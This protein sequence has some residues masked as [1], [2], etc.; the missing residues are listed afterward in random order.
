[1]LRVMTFNLRNSNAADGA[2]A[3]DERRDFLVDVIRAARVDVLGTQECLAEQGDFLSGRLK[4]Y[5]YLGVCRDDGCR[6]GEAAAILYRRERF[7]EPVDSG[8]FWL[9]E[10][11]QKIGSKGWDAALPRICTWA[12][13]RERDSGQEL[14]FVNTHFDH[15]GERARMESARQ[16]RR[17]I[18]DAGAGMPVVLTGD[19][20]APGD[21][22]VHAALLEGDRLRDAWRVAHPKPLEEE[23]TFHGF[24]GVRNRERIDWIVCSKEF[25]VVSCTTDHTCRDGRYPSDHFPVIAELRLAR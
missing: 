14:L 8:T 1:M 6:E 23:G 5:A 4:E 9:C 16:I 12:K 22:E 13:L 7:D 18:S 10:T 2:N 15:R 3:W 17:W 11:P 20:N 19:F 25:D 24:T 21:G